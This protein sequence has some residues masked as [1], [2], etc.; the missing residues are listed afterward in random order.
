MERF[1]TNWYAYDQ[2]IHGELKQRAQADL[3]AHPAVEQ[4]NSGAYSEIELIKSDS[5]DIEQERDAKT[6]RL[7]SGE[8][9]ESVQNL[10]GTFNNTDSEQPG[11]FSTAATRR[12]F[13]KR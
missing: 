3:L 13:T 7:N 9:D 12:R 8:W 1:L 2:R 4:M 11:G 5:S 10:A 6:I